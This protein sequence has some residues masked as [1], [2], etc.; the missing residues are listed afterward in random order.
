MKNSLELGGRDDPE[1]SRGFS[2]SRIILVGARRDARKLLQQMCKGPSRMMIVGFVDAG[3]Q[4]TCRP[5][6]IVT[7]SPSVD[8]FPL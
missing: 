1:I 8:P 6:L 5:K 3:H 2:R 7:G 4:P